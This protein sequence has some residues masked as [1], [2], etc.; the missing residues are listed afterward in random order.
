[1]YA[2]ELVEQWHLLNYNYS[3]TEMCSALVNV[4]CRQST[5]IDSKFRCNKSEAAANLPQ[6][7]PCVP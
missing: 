2:I 4:D 5:P 7:T 3:F 1:V 6:N